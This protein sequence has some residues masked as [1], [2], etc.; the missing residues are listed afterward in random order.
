MPIDRELTLARRIAGLN[1]WIT[2]GYFNS[3]SDNEIAARDAMLADGRLETRRWDNTN[4]VALTPSGQAWL[5]GQ[6]TD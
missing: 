5:N 3:S 6:T 1:G 4:I 2:A